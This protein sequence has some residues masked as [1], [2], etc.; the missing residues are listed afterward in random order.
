[1]C[2]GF[3]LQEY[4]QK[5][6]SWHRLFGSIY[7]HLSPHPSILAMSDNKLEHYRRVL[8]RALG[9]SG[10][11]I[12]VV[13]E[14]FLKPSFPQLSSVPNPPGHTR[15]SCCYTARCPLSPHWEHIL[16][17]PW[18]FIDG[19]L[20]INGKGHAGEHSYPPLSGDFRLWYPEQLWL[21][22]AVLCSVK[23]IHRHMTTAATPCVLKG[24]F[25]LKENWVCVFLISTMPSS[26][27]RV[28]GTI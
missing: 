28:A 12:C 9:N 14:L 10:V 27:Q 4:P 8:Q 1:M 2:V 6:W 5:T 16:S 20:P 15:M 24:C 18:S 19:N 17:D 26:K 22:R 23:I 11:L 7:S 21:A 13:T 25:V 3:P